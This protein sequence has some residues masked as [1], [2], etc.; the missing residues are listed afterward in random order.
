MQVYTLF[1]IRAFLKSLMHDG[2]GAS[3]METGKDMGL[4]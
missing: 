3:F 4:W 2:K 1:Q